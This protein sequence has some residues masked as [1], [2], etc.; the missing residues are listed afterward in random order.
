MEV[1]KR[2]LLLGIASGIFSQ[3]CLATGCGSERGTDSPEIGFY[4]ASVL[5]TIPSDGAVQRPGQLDFSADFRSSGSVWTKGL[6]EEDVFLASMDAGDWTLGI[7]KGGHIYSLRGSFGETIPPQ[8]TDSPWNDEVWQMVVTA[9]EV[10]TPIHDF[11]ALGR[12]QRR[13]TLPLMYFI[14]QSGIYVK[15]Q[16]GGID[17]GL[18]ARPF[19]SPVLRQAWDAERRAFSV[20]NWAQQARTPCVWRSG[21]LIFTEY[22]DLGDGIIEVTQVL[23]HSGEELLTHLNAPWGGVR[24]SL[25]PHTIMSMPD[26]SWEEVEGSWG[27]SNV[28]QRNLGD[29]GGWTA[30]AGDPADEG[31]PGLALVFGTEP[32]RLSDLKKRRSFVRYGTAANVAVRDYQVTAQISKIRLYPGESLAARWYLVIGSFGEVRARAAEMVPHAGVWRPEFNRSA[33]QPVWWSKGA[34]ATAGEGPASF[35]LFAHP[36]AG[37]VP[38]YSMEDTRSGKHF[39]TTDPYV[40]TETVPFPNPL[41]EDHPEFERYQGRVIYQQYASPG[42]LRDLLGFAYPTLLPGGSGDTARKISLPGANGESI[43]LWVPWIGDDLR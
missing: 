1:G 3:L 4:A 39:F 7:G 42:V 35:G 10:I 29:T 22:R 2:L 8:R 16:A 24:H 25:L 34:P 11:Q 19:Y 23:H 33:L 17:S 21:A 9:E 14:H 27:W 13:A 28:P 5:D 18:V 40:L 15:G 12:E 41:P 36:V 20:V 43:I 31:S 6:N 38:V 32:G 30:W 37:T 26:G